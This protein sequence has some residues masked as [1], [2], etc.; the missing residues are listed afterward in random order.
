V[1]LVD[2]RA[3]TEPVLWDTTAGVCAA[4]G[5]LEIAEAVSEHEKPLY[6]NAAINILKATDRRFCNWN[7]DED[8]IVANGTGS[9]HGRNGD[10]AE[11]I[12]YGDYFFIEA[13]LRLRGQGFLIW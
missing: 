9:Y 8:S 1:P 7:V 12:I 13:V 4:C 11:P 2:F 6:L 10:F 3:P 5:M